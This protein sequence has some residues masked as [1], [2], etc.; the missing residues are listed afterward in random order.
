[1]RRALPLC[2][3]QFHYSDR[4]INTRSRKF[5]LV[6]AKLG[7]LSGESSLNS[8]SI[9]H[10]TVRRV[11]FYD[12]ID[13]IYGLGVKLAGCKNRGRPSS[14]LS[15]QVRSLRLA[16]VC[17]IC[18][19]WLWKSKKNWSRYWCVVMILSGKFLAT[20][21]SPDRTRS[22]LSQFAGQKT[23]SDY[24]ISSR[25]MWP[26]CLLNQQEQQES[27]ITIYLSN[28]LSIYP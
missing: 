26:A 11:C 22:H 2:D 12:C 28:Y 27:C 4:I 23:H 25:L 5:R 9:L 14:G 19:A 24:W 15:G 10:W 18:L 6:C 21:S 8:S 17:P 1:M 13:I 7:E 20:G 16:S 3:Q